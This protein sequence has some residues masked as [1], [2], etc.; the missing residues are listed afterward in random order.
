MR[1]HLLVFENL[2]LVPDSYDPLV[3]TLETLAEKDLTL[4]MVKQRLLAEEMKHRLNGKGIVDEST[5]LL[6]RKLRSNPSQ[7]VSWEMSRSGKRDHFLKDCRQK[8]DIFV[9]CKLRQSILINVTKHGE[10]VGS[11]GC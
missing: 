4:E 10:N 6:F 2:I 5:Q 3:T 9:T 1:A 11:N 8:R 7:E